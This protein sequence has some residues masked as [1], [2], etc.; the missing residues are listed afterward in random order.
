MQNTIH[1]QLDEEWKALLSEA[2]QLGG[3]SIEEIKRFL[4]NA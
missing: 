3:L 1:N 2:K 4:E